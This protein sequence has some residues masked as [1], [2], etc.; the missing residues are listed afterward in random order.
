M[1]FESKVYVGTE[2][3]K[4][5]DYIDPDIA[6]QVIDDLI[7]VASKTFGGVTVYQ[8]DG[9]YE[10]SGLSV[11]EQSYVFEFLHDYPWQATQLAEKAK[12]ALNQESVLVTTRRV[13]TVEFV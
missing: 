5:G 4:D 1:N 11:T 12:H 10:Q 6:E 7:Q 8:V 13:E 3:D 9:S 2:W